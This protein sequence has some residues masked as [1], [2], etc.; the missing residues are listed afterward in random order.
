MLETQ[1]FLSPQ[2]SQ[3]HPRTSSPVKK[4]DTQ[5]TP[6]SRSKSK[7]GHSAKSIS[8]DISG[9]HGSSHIS[10]N[11]TASSF[12]S[13]STPKS[14]GD[15]QE[16]RSVTERTE[17]PSSILQLLR[18]V[19]NVSREKQNRKVSARPPLKKKTRNRK[20]P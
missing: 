14:E 9:D 19:F 18:Y 13:Y 17:E 12:P 10:P 6:S 1:C 5:S 20:R 7:A 16:R 15:A 11:I 2:P 3:S 4:P 8:E